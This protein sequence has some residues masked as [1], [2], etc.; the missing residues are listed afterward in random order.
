[1]GEEAKPQRFDPRILVFAESVQDRGEDVRVFLLRGPVE[2]QF[3]G[4]SF[5]RAWGV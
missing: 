4:A 3:K 2:E 5:E 1:M